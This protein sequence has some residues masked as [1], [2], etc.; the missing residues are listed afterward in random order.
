M[1]ADILPMVP[2]RRRRHQQEVAGGQFQ[3][4]ECGL[5]GCAGLLTGNRVPAKR[6][7]SEFANEFSAGGGLD[8]TYIMASRGEKPEQL[9]SLIGRDAAGNRK[10]DSFAF[11]I[12]GL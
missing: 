12:H 9:G 1:P 4:A 2:A 5:G 11:A 10:D 7:K 6:L 3:V 8:H